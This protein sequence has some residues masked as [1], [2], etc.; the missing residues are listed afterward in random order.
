[1]TPEPN[2]LAARRLR[3]IVRFFYWAVRHRS[4][5]RATWVTQY[6]GLHW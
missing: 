4:V 2:T 5:S 6:E 3:Y 1:M